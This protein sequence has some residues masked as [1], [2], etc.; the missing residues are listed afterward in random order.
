MVSN[1]QVH[2]Y[3]HRLHDI[4]ALANYTEEVQKQLNFATDWKILFEAIPIHETADHIIETSCDEV[5]DTATISFQREFMDLKPEEIRYYVVHEL[6]HVLFARI[7]DTFVVIKGHLSEEIYSSFTDMHI[8]S[9]ER[10]VDRLASVIAPLVKLP[11][12]SSRKRKAHGRSDKA[13]RNEEVSG[14]GG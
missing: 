11:N 10:F 9:E 5:T 8:R 2:R 12:F 14:D 1:R 3:V 13:G 7:D 4:R 6:L